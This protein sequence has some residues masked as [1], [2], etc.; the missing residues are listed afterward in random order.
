MKDKIWQ[1]W[2][3]ELERAIDKATEHEVKIRMIGKG[4]LYTTAAIAGALETI[5]EKMPEK[6]DSKFHYETKH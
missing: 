2:V 5:A 1:K 6:I 3:L 4:L